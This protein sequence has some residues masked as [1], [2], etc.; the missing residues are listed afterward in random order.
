MDVLSG[1]RLEVGLGA[2]V[3][4]GE[5]DAMG[6]SFEEAPRR[7]SKLEEMVELIKLHSRGEQLDFPGA[8]VKAVGYAGRPLPVQR[9]HPPIM[10]GGSRKRV[11]SLAAREADVVSLNN[12]EWHP[13]NAAGLTPMQELERRF[14]MVREAAGERFER[15]EVESSPYAIEVTES[16]QEALER[17][18]SR[19]RVVVPEVSP[20]TLREHP[21]VL[22]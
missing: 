14:Q 2:G 5:Y 21:N 13:V 9:P 8:Y 1:G 17:W 19:L 15:L 6:I 20:E 11:L 22:I 12:V 16:V 7:V 4:A 18:A 10:I 3:N